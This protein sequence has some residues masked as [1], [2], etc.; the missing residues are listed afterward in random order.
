MGRVLSKRV[1]PC[2]ETLRLGY[3]RVSIKNR[4]GFAIEIKRSFKITR[5]VTHRAVTSGAVKSKIFHFFK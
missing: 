3:L 2:V 1:S 4:A 5:R